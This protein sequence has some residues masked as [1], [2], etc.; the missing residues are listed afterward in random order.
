MGVDDRNIRGCMTDRYEAVFRAAPDGILLVEAD[1]TIAEANPEALRLFGY[2][3]A[4]LV[5]QSVDI[6]VPEGVRGGHK[7][8][9]TEYLR[10][11]HPRPM[12]I[13]LELQA[14]GKNGV[15]IPVEISLSPLS[16]GQG[17]RI[18]AIV[19][20]LTERRR[21]KGFGAGALRAAEEERRRIARELHDDTAQ[22]MASL[23]MRLRVLEKRLAG[24]PALEDI[25][26]M[27]AWLHDTMEGVRRIARGLRPPELED[28]GLAAA[29]RRFVRERFDGTTVE[30]EFDGAEDHLAPE[31][32]LVLYRIAQEALSNA[33]RHGGAG[34]VQLMIGRDS[35]SR[36]VRMQIVDD[37]RGFEPEAAGE[38]GSGL[39]L[40]GMDERAQLAGGRLRVESRPGEGARISVVLPLVPMA[41]EG[42]A[43]RKAGA[44]E[45]VIDDG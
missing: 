39:G 26:R 43:V 18:I 29:L 2:S 25:G 30:F 1:G 41:E 42:G 31:Q 28:V 22:S 40:V 16:S 10:N 23:L 8:H 11:P 9:R 13:G 35:A 20:D 15:R 32:Q 6:L 38:P 4:E 19:R 45:G 33:V 14:V 34:H 7:R 17:G 44:E 24:H 21:L 3:S 27:R 12:G 5:G 37:G 36:G